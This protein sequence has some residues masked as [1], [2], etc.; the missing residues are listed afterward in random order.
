MA[1]VPPE[2]QFLLHTVY[3]TLCRNHYVRCKTS[4]ITGKIMLLC[5][6]TELKNIMMQYPMIASYHV[7]KVE[8]TSTG[9][10]YPE[11]KTAIIKN[12]EEN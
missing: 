7:M 10:E 3:V 5:R 1:V 12:E 4:H 8:D 6:H 11:L 2:K 9:K